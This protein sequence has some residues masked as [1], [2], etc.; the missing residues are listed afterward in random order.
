MD[1]DEIHLSDSSDEME[2]PD[3][4][5]CERGEGSDCSSNTPAQEEQESQA[6]VA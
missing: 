1:R 5:S 3:K 6:K 4:A 2:T